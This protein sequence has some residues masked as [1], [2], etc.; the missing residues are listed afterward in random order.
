MW[1][2]LDLKKGK[3]QPQPSSD[4]E[5]ALRVICRILT[6]MVIDMQNACDK[7]ETSDCFISGYFSVLRLLKQLARDDPR[8]VEYA[9]STW[10]KF[11]EDKNF[12]RKEQCPDIGALLPLLAITSHAP[13]NS[14]EVIDWNWVKHAYVEE[15]SL[16]QVKWCVFLQM[17][18]SSHGSLI[19]YF[20]F[21]Y[22][23]ITNIY[24]LL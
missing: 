7:E 2:D 16:R 6:K 22:I 4:E 5:V 15:S 10:T 24:V 12:R 14:S 13:G 11:K 17:A 23:M 21:Y 20:T 9:N 1:T 8:L 18:L 3:G 19:G